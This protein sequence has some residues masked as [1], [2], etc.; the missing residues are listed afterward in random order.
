[1]WRE[2]SFGDAVENI[3]IDLA[4]NITWTKLFFNPGVQFDDVFVGVPHLLRD[5]T[6]RIRS[7][8]VGDVAGIAAAD[9]DHHRF[10]SFQYPPASHYRSSRVEPSCANRSVECVRIGRR[11]AKRHS[12]IMVFHVETPD[13]ED[14]LMAGH[15]QDVLHQRPTFK[16]L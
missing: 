3:L 9:I 2:R 11:L 1:M 6:E 12:T 13:A 15:P 7:G 8:P 4:G 14:S 5:R 16:L 10:V